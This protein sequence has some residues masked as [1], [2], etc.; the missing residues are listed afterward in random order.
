MKKILLLLVLASAALVI[1]EEPKKTANSNDSVTLKVTGMNCG[2]CCAPVQEALLK[3]PG[4]IKAEVD[5]AT[6]SATVKYDKT[7]VTPK[8][9]AAAQVPEG[10]TVALV[11]TKKKDS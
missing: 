5:F 6:G 7:K 11:K 4:V 1:A 10:R 2:A 9:I 8:Q 3:V